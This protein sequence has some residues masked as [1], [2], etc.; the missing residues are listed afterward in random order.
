MEIT[1]TEQFWSVAEEGDLLPACVP[2]P[3]GLAS[4]AFGIDGN[5]MAETLCYSE[6]TRERAIA[7]IICCRQIHLAMAATA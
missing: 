4:T 3:G 7:G 5:Q 1:A 2:F 6:N